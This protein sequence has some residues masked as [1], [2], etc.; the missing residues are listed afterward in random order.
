MFGKVK[1]FSFK[2]NDQGKSGWFRNQNER[3]GGFRQKDR[4]SSETGNALN[5]TDID[6]TKKLFKIN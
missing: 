4:Q 6:T 1:P 5:Y 2:T 3:K